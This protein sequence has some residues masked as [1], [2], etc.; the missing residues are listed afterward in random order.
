MAKNSAKNSSGFQRAAVLKDL[1]N[2]PVYTIDWNK[3]EGCGV[4][5]TGGGSLYDYY[6][7]TIPTTLSHM[8]GSRA[9]ARGRTPHPHP[10]CTID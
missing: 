4:I 5:T 9:R 8:P 6:S 7:C 10:I 3:G 1:H 2:R